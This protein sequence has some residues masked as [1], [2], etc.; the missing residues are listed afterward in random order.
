MNAGDFFNI[1]KEPSTGVYKD[2][3]SSFLSFIYPILHESAVKSILFTLKKE[4]PKAR[5]ICHAYQWGP[6]PSYFRINDDGEPGGT[7]GNPIL[8]QLKSHKLDNTLL[9]VVRYF[10]GT[11]LGVPGLIN[12]YKQSALH[13]IQHASIIIMRRNVYFNIS[14]SYSM[15]KNLLSFLRKNDGEIISKKYA[16]SIEI[17]ASFPISLHQKIVIQSIHQPNVNRQPN[18]GIL[19]GGGLEYLN[20]RFLQKDDY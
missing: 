18:E 14:A 11:L 5:H 8:N 13:V 10:G 7:A 12:A 15:E 3:G 6:D 2:K 17:E 4:H 19:P 1:V 9:V 16:E 20:V